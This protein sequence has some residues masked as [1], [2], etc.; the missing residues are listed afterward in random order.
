VASGGAPRFQ[1]KTDAPSAVPPSGQRK[2]VR[3]ALLIALAQDG[4]TDLHISTWDLVLFS[5]E[6]GLSS[7]K[8]R[9]LRMEEVR[10]DD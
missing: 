10:D 4:H 8:E 5:L 6:H 2:A 7:Q 3:K 1:S 9:D